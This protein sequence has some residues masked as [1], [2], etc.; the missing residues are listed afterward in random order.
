MQSWFIHFPHHHFFRHHFEPKKREREDRAEMKWEG[1][2]V[3]QQNRKFWQWK[4]KSKWGEKRAERKLKVSQRKKNVN[5]SH[6]DWQSTWSFDW[7]CWARRRRAENLKIQHRC[8]EGQSSQTD[9]SEHILS[10]SRFINLSA[11]IPIADKWKYEMF[12]I[13]DSFF[14][15]SELFF[16]RPV[17]AWTLLLGGGKKRY[18]KSVTRIA[19]QSTIIN[20]RENFFFTEFGSDDAHTRK[21]T[22]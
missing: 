16:V 4:I 13:C 3:L 11:R 15:C 7:T 5:P 21:F 17:C 10:S 14:F 9:D 8:E 2:K 12:L 20:A 1:K 22:R 18:E 6:H 19:S